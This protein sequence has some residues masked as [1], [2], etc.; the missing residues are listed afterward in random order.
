VESNVIPA[1]IK[2]YSHSALHTFI[3]SGSIM[4]DGPRS[5]TNPYRRR[6]GLFSFLGLKD[7]LDEVRREESSRPLQSQTKE[8]DLGFSL[9][10]VSE[11]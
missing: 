11:A 8:R 10:Q 3:T 9:G 2:V 5:K 4:P 7:V 1:Q 6:P